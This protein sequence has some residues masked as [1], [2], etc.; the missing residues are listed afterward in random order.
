NGR[1][2]ARVVIP[3]RLRPY[4]DGRAELEIQ[5]G[6]DLRTARRKHAAAVAT[7]QHQIAVAEDRWRDA[8]N[9]TV[10][11]RPRYTLPPDQLA[12]I[13]Y[14]SQLDFDQELRENYPS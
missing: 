4:L 9:P 7:I 10:K 6:G 2:S 1:Y 5:L 14:N 12:A 11:P 8:Q 13:H 3:P